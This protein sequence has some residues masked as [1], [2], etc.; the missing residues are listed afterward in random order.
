[1]IDVTRLTKRQVRIVSGVLLALMCIALGNVYLEIHLF[2][3]FDKLF[4]IFVMVAIARVVRFA[5]APQRR[6]TMMDVI[7]APQGSLT[8]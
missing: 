8:A 4:A 2:G 7:N 5:S 1:M 3:R 6:V